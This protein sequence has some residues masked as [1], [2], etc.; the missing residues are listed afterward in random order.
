MTAFFLPALSPLHYRI[1]LVAAALALLA[2][3]AGGGVALWRLPSPETSS[4]PDAQLRAALASA[5]GAPTTVSHSPLRMGEVRE[6]IVPGLRRVAVSAPAVLSVEPQG[7]G[8]LRLT[9]AVEGTT[10]LVT[11]TGEA[12]EMK[13]ISV[14][15]TAH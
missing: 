6:L 13:I 3:M 7:D 2:L 4:D 14:T 5:A 15:V 9:G 11:W 10:Y 1:R 12:F 8:K